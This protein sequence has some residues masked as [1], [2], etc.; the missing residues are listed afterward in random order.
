M[1][2]KHAL[3]VGAGVVVAVCALYLP[4]LGAP[5][6]Y[7]DKVEIRDGT[8]TKRAVWRNTYNQTGVYTERLYIPHGA[9][10]YSLTVLMR[11]TNGL[12]YEDMFH[13]GYNVNY[14]DG[15]GLML[16]LPLLLATITIFLGSSRSVKWD[17]DDY[18]A[19]DRN[20]GGLGILG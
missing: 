1:T 16:W 11:T 9:G 3:L 15:F 2:R 14:M 17:D 10:Y 7:D 13:I 4:S 8:S 6:E 5:F 18:E 20:G 19:R 12:I